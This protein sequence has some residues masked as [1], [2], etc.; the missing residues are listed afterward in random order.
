MSKKSIILTVTVCIGLLTGM[1]WAQTE[2]LIGPARKLRYVYAAETNSSVNGQGTVIKRDAGTLF[3]QDAVLFRGEVRVE[4][5]SVILGTSL[6][7]KLTVLPY[8]ANPSLTN[9]LTFWVDASSNVVSDAG[10]VSHWLDV[11]DTLGAAQTNYP[12]AALPSGVTAP[13]LTAA[14]I[15]FGAHDSGSWLQWADTTTNALQRTDICTVVMAIS[16]TNGGGCFFGSSGTSHFARGSA[17]AG[18]SRFF[19][20]HG[21]SSPY[22]IQGDVFVDEVRVDALKATPKAGDQ[23]LAF[24]TRSVS[25]S[26]PVAASNFGNDRNLETG[27]FRLY[28]VLVYNR[29]LNEAE[30]M[31]VSDYL[32]GKWFK[33][34]IAGDLDLCSGTGVELAADAGRSLVSGRLHGGGTVTKSGEG[35]WVIENLEKPFAGQV[36]LQ[37][38]SLTNASSVMQAV[39]FMVSADALSVVA[40]ARSWRV[41]ESQTA[42]VMEKSGSGEWLVTGLPQAGVQTV[43]VAAGTLRLAGREV[44]SEAQEAEGAAVIFEDSFEF[45]YAQLACSTFNTGVKYSLGVYGDGWV[46]WPQIGW[47]CRVNETSTTPRNPA[48]VLCNEGNNA[49]QVVPGGAEQ[50]N[51]ALLLQGTGEIRRDVTFPSDG[52]YLLT[53]WAAARST[54]ICINHNFDVCV[55]GVTVTN[56]LTTVYTHFRYY[57]VALTNITAGVHELRFTG[58]NTLAPTETYRAS[59]L[60]GIR[61]CAIED[62]GAVADSGFEAGAWVTSAPANPTDGIWEYGALSGWTA[63]ITDHSAILYRL[64]APEGVKVAWLGNISTFAATNVTFSQAGTYALSFLAAGRQTSG[65]AEAL[66]GC[67]PGHDYRVFFDGMACGYGRTMNR[68]FERQEIL[69]DVAAPGTYVVRFYGINEGNLQY[70]QGQSEYALSRISLFDSINVRKVQSVPVSDYSFENNNTVNWKWVNNPLTSA[71]GNNYVPYSQLPDGPS[72][73]ARAGILMGT[74]QMY[75]D[76]TF[77]ADGVFRLSFYAAGRFLYAGGLDPTRTTAAVRLGHDFRVCMDGETVMTVQ[78]MDEIYHL[79]DV[80]LPLLKAG[81][82]RLSFEGINTLGGSDRGSSFDAVRL[83]AIETASADGLLPAE[84]GVEVAVGAVLHLDYPGTNDVKTVKLGGYEPSGLITAERFPMYI[85]GTGALYTVPK[86]TM[87]MIK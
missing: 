50:G 51:Q 13:L 39:P 32:D 64:G 84:V 65:A 85:Q 62:S 8:V 82:H 57:Q 12:W 19:W 42:G 30:R 9:G 43:R 53:F 21:L 10:A 78:T 48:I 81:V 67:W 29:A 24:V 59:V 63:A 36:V 23:V 56:V 45:P 15:D 3:Y 58:T 80:R 6:D 71:S 20:K 22:L 28:E 18:G 40:D 77:P 2:S 61:I 35:T 73:N 54:P 70:F 7:N 75:Q 68:R 60:D 49:G 27:G 34:S 33:R 38:G 1:A 44:V 14:G 17:S 4:E 25:G 31:R 16:C 47:T 69:F 79:Y 52:N 5:G 55:G 83:T 26:T 66:Q 37:G 87:I 46:D 86:G 76:I 11:R 74:G 41:A 72:S